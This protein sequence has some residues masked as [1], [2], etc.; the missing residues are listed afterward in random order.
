MIVDK[1]LLNEYTHTTGCLIKK[2]EVLKVIKV[3]WGILDAKGNGDSVVS[4]HGILQ[5]K[6]LECLVT[7]VV[8][9]SLRPYGT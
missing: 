5:A 3:S 1:H 8:S 7:L 6:I 2:N 9:D 4:V